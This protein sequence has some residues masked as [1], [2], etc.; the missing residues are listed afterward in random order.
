MDIYIQKLVER[1]VTDNYNHLWIHGLRRSGTTAVWKM[2]KNLDGYTAFDEPFNPLL[3]KNL[4]Q[5]HRKQTWDEFIEL[6]RK[7]SLMKHLVTIS[8]EDE[9]VQNLELDYCNY[10]DY[11]LQQP[12]IIDFTRLNFKLQAVI[13]KYRY[14]NHLVLFRNPIAFATSHIINSENTKIGRQLYYRSFFWTKNVN[15]NSWGLNDIIHGNAFPKLLAD[16]EIPLRYQISE[17]SPVECCLLIWLAHWRYSL[18]VKDQN[19]NANIEIIFLEDIYPGCEQFTRFLSRAGIEIA[20][21][22]RVHLTRPATGFCADDTRWKNAAKKVGYNRT[23]I[24]KFM[25]DS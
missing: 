20:A 25:Q 21:L 22:R 9:A 16:L 5:Q 7:G 13:E 2:F 8:P 18:K 1:V 19:P 12:T 23:E 3:L 4:P 10:L 24:E 17:L 6:Y 15:F 14:V 11:L